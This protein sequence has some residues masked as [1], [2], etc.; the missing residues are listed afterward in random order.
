MGEETPVDVLKMPLGAGAD[1]TDRVHLGLL[2]VA[3]VRQLSGVGD[4]KVPEL[5]EA[6][7][8]FDPRGGGAG[9]GVLF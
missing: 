6:A 4:S 3:L 2:R 5:D 8:L 7:A 1:E 9:S